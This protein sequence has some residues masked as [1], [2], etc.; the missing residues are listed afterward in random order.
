MKFCGLTRREDVDAAMTLGVDAIGFVLTRRSKRFVELD[1]AASLRAGV[2]PFV[3]VV[4]LVMDDE[5][6]WIEEVI[7]RLA[8]DLLQFH[9]GETAD[10]CT[11]FGRRYLKAVPMASVVDVAA[12]VREHPQAAGFLL[13]SHAVG[14]QGGTGEADWKRMPRDVARPL[15]LAGGLHAGNVEQAVRVARPYAVDVS[16]GIEASPGIKDVSRM[17]QFA[18]ALYQAGAS[19]DQPAH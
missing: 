10:F 18:Q 14:G 11:Q 15:I 5:P 12:Y 6:A 9:G 1:L 4:A 19:N 3:D 16:S 2:A 13:D 8:P 7:S 17:K